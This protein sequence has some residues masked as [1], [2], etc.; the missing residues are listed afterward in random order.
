MVKP[1]YQS[2]VYTKI[3]G[4][5]E[6]EGKVCQDDSAQ[7]ASGEVLI[8]AVSDGH[9]ESN[10][11][12]SDR[13]AKYAVDCAINGAREF[14]YKCRDIPP[15]KGA[16]DPKETLKEMIASLVTSIAS[17]WQTEV[18]QDFNEE[19]FTQE[20]LALCD[21]KHRKQFEA[22]KDP[23]KAYGATLI[24]AAI[25]EKYW[26]G[27]HIGD[28][29][30]TALKDAPDDEELFS[31]PVIWDERCYLN[32]TTSICD[33][34]ANERPRVY[35]EL[36]SEEEPPP[37]ALFLCSDGIDDN[38]PVENNEKHLYQ[39]YA[40]IA[41]AF[42]ED[43]FES[44]SKQIKELCDA[45]AKKGKGD[46]T[47]LAIVID[48]ERVKRM[49]EKLKKVASKP[50]KP[51]IEGKTPIDTK[52][53]T[54]ADKPIIPIKRE[55]TISPSAN[56]TQNAQAARQNPAKPNDAASL[57]ER[58]IK[59]GKAYDFYKI[60]Q[61]ITLFLSAICVALAA[62]ITFDDGAETNA[63]QPPTNVVNNRGG[64]SSASGNLALIFFAIAIREVCPDLFR[65]LASGDKAIAIY[66]ACPNLPRDLVGD[67]EL[68][69]TERDKQNETI[70]AQDDEQSSDTS[71]AAQENEERDENSAPQETQSDPETQNNG[72]ESD[73]T[74]RDEQESDANTSIEGSI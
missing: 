40:K 58:Q 63:A 38:Y 28:G 9:G 13:G 16:L 36:I 26:F 29:R 18:G 7:Y 41:I 70:A 27:F 65:N 72:V 33:Y 69:D 32:V 53:P 43:G 23:F 57:K 64:D 49:S 30:F 71:Q 48:M 25:T 56:Q 50:V 44:A 55:A 42:A 20:E 12:R 52:T 60:L 21:E 4:S 5:H 34:S 68:G 54:I 2:F 51:P 31:Q 59:A 22:G 15:P 8:V 62:Y 14:A 3:G 17:S 19:P 66:E 11:F 37:V 73:A 10:C 46:D 45:F 6:K 39:L 35:C 24:V 47:S 67:G 74:A 1:A 61:I